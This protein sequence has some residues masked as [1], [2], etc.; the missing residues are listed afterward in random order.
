MYRY[1]GIFLDEF[2]DLGPKDVECARILRFVCGSTEAPWLKLVV[3]GYALESE[4]LHSILGDHHLLTVT[5]RKYTLERCQIVSAVAGDSL[6]RIATQLTTAALNRS[7]DQAGNVMVFLPGWKEICTVQHDLMEAHPGLYVLLLHSE[8]VGDVNEDKQTVSAVDGPMVVLS[9]VIGARSI[10]LSGMKYVIIHPYVR[11][12]SLHASGIT[13]IRDR[14]VSKELIGNMGGRAG[15]ESDGMVT[16][17]SVPHSASGQEQPVRDSSET[18]SETILQHLEE[19]WH[20]MIWRG[21]I[22]GTPLL[23]SLPDVP[24][25]TRHLVT[26]RYHDLQWSP[27][28]MSPRLASFVDEAKKAGVGLEAMRIACILERGA[29]TFN[30]KAVYLLEDESPQGC[31]LLGLSEV[32]KDL[33]RYLGYA[34]SVAKERGVTMTSLKIY[35]RRLKKARDLE[36]RPPE[37][38]SDI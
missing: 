2:S 34:E 26:L 13:I 5:G 23:E 27:L 31:P 14:L 29:G 38:A 20:I 30:P 9:T 7:G 32:L 6:L 16:E 24:A 28:A 18:V 21:T 15:R 37:S 8:V 19:F 11:S 25:A 1:G 10:T 22:P 4:Y 12:S 35:S 3:A 36:K 17:L 33:E